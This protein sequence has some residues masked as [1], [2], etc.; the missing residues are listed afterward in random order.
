MTN[1]AHQLAREALSWPNSSFLFGLSILLAACLFQA[2]ERR[3]ENDSSVQ[4]TIVLVVFKAV[5]ET[6]R[7]KVWASLAAVVSVVAVVV[8]LV[9]VNIVVERERELK[10]P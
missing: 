10:E 7:R 3:D 8:V 4:M 6:T 2:A 5:F 1:L 9:V